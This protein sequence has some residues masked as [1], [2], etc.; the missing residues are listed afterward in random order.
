MLFTVTPVSVA[1]VP[2]AVPPQD[3][4]YHLQVAPVPR[5]PPVTLSVTV[6]GPQSV[7]ALALA[8]VAAVDSDCTVIV[9][10]AVTAGHPPAAAI[11]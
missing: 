1:P 11:V 5:A 6:P 8:A 3:P 7:V 9:V 4:L 2:T 10:V